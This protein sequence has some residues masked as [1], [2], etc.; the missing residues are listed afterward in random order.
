[1]DCF[2]VC[3]FVV[4]GIDAGAEEEPSVSAIYD[5]GGTPEL[6]EIGLV[7]LVARGYETVDLRVDGVRDGWK[8]SVRGA[9]V[10]RL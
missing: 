7:F 1:M 10:L 4:I 8:G 6:N 2:E 3:K 9:Y 5:F